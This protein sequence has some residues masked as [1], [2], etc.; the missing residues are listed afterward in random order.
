MTELLTLAIVALGVGAAW[1]FV[2][3]LGRRPPFLEASRE[4]ALR[5]LEERRSRGSISRDEFEERRRRLLEA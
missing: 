3:E 2:R 1:R 5:L 4:E